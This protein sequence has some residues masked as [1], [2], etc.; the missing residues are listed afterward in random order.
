M[1]ANPQNH[2]AYTSFSRINMSS[3]TFSTALRHA[4]ALNWRL[5]GT[6]QDIEWAKQAIEATID[7][8]PA[9]AGKVDSAVI[10]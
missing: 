6:T 8:I 7:Q 9:L 3:R 4:K 1:T 2:A 5:N 10:K